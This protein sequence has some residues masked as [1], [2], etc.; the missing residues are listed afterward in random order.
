MGRLIKLHTIIE[1]KLQKSRSWY[2]G[3]QGKAAEF[4]MPTVR[5]NPNLWDEEVIDKWV[6][7]FVAKAKR[8]QSPRKILPS[9]QGATAEA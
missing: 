1:T 6:A 5:G 3:P 7:D 8:E 4:P 2:R 9:R